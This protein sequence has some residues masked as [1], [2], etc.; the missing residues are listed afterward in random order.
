MCRIYARDVCRVHIC[1]GFLPSQQQGN[2]CCLG[3]EGPVN[4]CGLGIVRSV[5]LRRVGSGH[6]GRVE[7]LLCHMLPQC[8]RFSDRAQSS[9][10][11][12]IN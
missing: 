10:D 12:T 3:E 1:C 6:N 2:N 8:A 11:V 4:S 7:H 9:N 5:Y